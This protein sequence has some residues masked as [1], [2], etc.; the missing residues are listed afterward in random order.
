MVKTRTSTQPDSKANIEVITS[1]SMPLAEAGL[2]SVMDI[3]R[4]E[5]EVACDVSRGVISNQSA[6]A[7][8]CNIGKALKGI[9]L[10]LKHGPK[11][12][13]QLMLK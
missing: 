7:I 1:R 11:D 4:Y 9:E 10:Q 12:Q 3:V 2:S 6:S 5:L 13:V 8:A